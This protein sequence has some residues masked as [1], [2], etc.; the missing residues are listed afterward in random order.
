MEDVKNPFNHILYEIQ[1]YLVTYKI[2]VLQNH[3]LR[4][5]EKNLILDGRAIH[6]R[7]L[8]IFFYKEKSGK[9]WHVDDYVNNS[10]ANR[11]FTD[12]TLFKDIK[13]YASRATGHLLDQR[14]KET[15]KDETGKCYQ[16]AYPVIVQSI[17]QFFTA[18]ENDVKNEYKINWEDK[19]IQ[20]IV[21]FIKHDL[22]S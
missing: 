2:N 13:N 20:G 17:K 14:L 16:K 15:Y 8:V 18:M 5:I 1:M 21:R 11:C 7:N 6:L 12:E 10:I 19:D 9:N 4:N 3:P 22:L